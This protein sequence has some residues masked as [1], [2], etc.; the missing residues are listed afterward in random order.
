MYLAIKEAGKT[1]PNAIAEVKEA[2][3]F[4]RYYAA[5]ITADWSIEAPAPLGPVVCIS[6]WNFPLAIFV[7]EVAA[8]LAAGN[9]VLAK[10][11][12]QTNLIAAYAVELFYQAGVPRAALQFLPGLGEVVGAALTQDQ[13]VKGVIFTGSAEVAR[14]I[15]QTL[16]ARADGQEVV[17]IAETGGQ[18]A[19]IVDS[20]ALPEQVVADVLSSAFDSAGQ[21]CSALRVLY[22]QENV[23][24]KILTMLKGA[25]N[26]LCVGNPAE[27]ATDI[28][29]V[30]D[31]DAQQALLM[32][33]SKLKKT[34]ASSHQ[35][36]LTEAA[37]LG[38]FVTPTLFE[39]DDL[40]ALEHEVFG[41]VLHVLRFKADELPKV[42]QQINATGFGLTHGVHSRID[43]TINSVIQ[44]VKAG[45]VYVNRNIVGAVVGVQ[46]FGGEGLSGTGPKAGGAYYLYRLTQ[47]PTWQPLQVEARQQAVTLPA[48]TNLLLW[49]KDKY[50]E[51]YK[52]FANVAAETPLAEKVQ[53]VSYTGENNEAYCA[54]RGHVA[55]VA[56]NE[57]SLCQQL[58]AAYATGN[59]AVVPATPLTL[60]LQE[61]LGAALITAENV[62]QVA[63]LQAVLF[64]GSPEEATAIRRQLAARKG[65]IVAFV[66]QENAGYNLHRLVVERSVS[67]NT[68]AA[69]GNASLM[70]M[71]L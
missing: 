57:G 45:N 43:E 52:K 67:I 59:V 55:C 18:N 3:D 64:E 44:T 32:H 26:E 12:E 27:L 37:R 14:L 33:I 36:T 15:N 1:L 19:M 16:A 51:Q 5:Q 6:P 49:L 48:L 9:V 30:I 46:P 50:P 2:V 69:G 8:A 62:L 24:D 31:T 28:G 17:L 56:S 21:R 63:D 4:C 13:R 25:M 41:P 65:A 58:V 23:A 61:K 70:A 47:A 7:G 35:S 60:A 10:P 53:F 11:A 22:L 40:S 29:P 20:S 38:H 39:I 34:A 66:A 42:M 68:T 54:P 71:S